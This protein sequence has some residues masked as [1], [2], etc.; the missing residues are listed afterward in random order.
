MQTVQDNYR[1]G[2]VIPPEKP[3]PENSRIFFSQKCHIEIGVAGL[4]QSARLWKIKRKTLSQSFFFTR[5]TCVL[6]SLGEGK[7]GHEISLPSNRK[8]DQSSSSEALAIVW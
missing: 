1:F 4:L 6:Y 5:R 2:K 3:V 7:A 8:T